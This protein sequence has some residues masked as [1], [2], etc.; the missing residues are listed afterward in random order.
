MSLDYNPYEHI[1]VVHKEDDT[2]VV[3]C[4]GCGGERPQSVEGPI[5]LDTPL[6][7]LFEI[8]AKHIAYS[9]GRLREDFKDW[10]RF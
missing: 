3:Y 2:Y 7:R 4:H 10:S 6:K 1:E 9:H 5:T 8:A